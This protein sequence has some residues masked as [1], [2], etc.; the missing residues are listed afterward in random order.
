MPK[1]RKLLFVIADGEHVRFVQPA[2]NNALHSD[3]SMD[4]VSAHKQSAQLGSDQPG[5][6]FHSGSSV[7]HALAPRHDPHRLEKAKFA[8]A[9]AAQLDTAAADGAFE[10]LVIVAPPHTASTIRQH[11][12]AA[13]DA[14]VVGTLHKD[15][16]KTPDDELWP[17]LR[18]WI[19]PVHRP[20]S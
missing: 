3:A 7:H 16:V 17:H 2:E 15:L 1:N 11:L 5:A 18:T 12:D 13:T 19:R 4:S 20:A 14:L 9:I 10:E 8:E 6:S